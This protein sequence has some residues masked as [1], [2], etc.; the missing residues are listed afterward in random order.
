M[1]ARASG[2]SDRT[3]TTHSRHFTQET[4]EKVSCYFEAPDEA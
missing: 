2:Q 3:R 4:S 1:K